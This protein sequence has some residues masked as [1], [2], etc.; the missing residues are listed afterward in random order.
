MSVKMIPLGING[1]FPFFGRHTMSI[2]LLT[3]GEAVLLD[4]GTGVSRLSEPGI[5]ELVRPY[6]RLNVILS[7][8]HL[9][10]IMGL[11]YLSGVWKQ[12]RVRIYAPGKPFVEVDP[13]DTLKQVLRPPFF[14]VTL[15]NFPIPVELIPVT[16]EAVQIGKLSIRLRAQNHPGGSTGVRINDTIA[17]V[18]DTTVGEGTE[19]FVRGV[20][21]L[22][23][24][25]Y[26]TD[27]EA[28]QDPVERSRHSS[29]SAVAQLAKRAGVARLMPIHHNPW[30][31]G[32][33]IAKMAQEMESLSG[34]EVLIPE[35]GT[36]YEL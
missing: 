5:R 30:R 22:L 16:D 20:N 33:E 4:A 13:E 24:E 6:D 8:Y 19:P 9:D 23:H 35:E 29:V 21:L 17:Y 26:L 2:L 12:G 18:T 34:I 14:P 3:P 36:V 27:A 10:H 15:E 28:G 11:S 31:T 7:H 25:V 1:F 32:P